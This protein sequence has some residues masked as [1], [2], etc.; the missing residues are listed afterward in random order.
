MIYLTVVC[1]L[2][3]AL[4]AVVLHDRAR[5][6]GEWAHERGEWTRERGDLLQRIQAPAQAVAEHTAQVTVLRS[7]PAVATENDEDYWESREELAERLAAA[8]TS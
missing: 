7:P 8:E 4:V 3:L 1:A 2:A 6:R 5:E